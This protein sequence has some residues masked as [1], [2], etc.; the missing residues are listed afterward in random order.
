M[1]FFGKKII[2]SGDDKRYRYTNE[3]MY[4]KSRLCSPKTCGKHEAAPRSARIEKRCEMSVE[5][6]R[7]LSC[8][9]D[10]RKSG[11]DKKQKR[12]VSCI[13][14]YNPPLCSIMTILVVIIC[15]FSLLLQSLLQCRQE[16]FLS[17][18]TAPSGTDRA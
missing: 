16:A 3:K 9:S 14:P 13:F 5:K 2:L 10:P 8:K 11:F 4:I 12:T 18:S 17:L 1:H 7:F 6:R 15:H